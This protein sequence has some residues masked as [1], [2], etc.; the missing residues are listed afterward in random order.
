MGKPIGIETKDL[1]KSFLQPIV[2]PI[3]GGISGTQEPISLFSDSTSHFHL[4]YLIKF[5]R[6]VKL[7]LKHLE[8]FLYITS[9]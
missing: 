8:Y 1:R 7:I 4:F 3:C 6:E 9:I 2:E 5:G